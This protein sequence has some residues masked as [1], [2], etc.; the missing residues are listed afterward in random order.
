MRKVLTNSA[1]ERK[2]YRAAFCRLGKKLGY[3]GYS[4]ETILLKD[5]TDLETNQV[6]ADHIWFAYTQG[7]Q[8]VNL[9]EGVLVE[10]EARVKKYTKGYVNPRLKVNNK[11]EDYKLSNP[12]KIKVVK[13]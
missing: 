7:F 2:K 12:T 8:K 3:L 5:V 4:E 9:K 11:R 6:V 13:V 1:G 10:F